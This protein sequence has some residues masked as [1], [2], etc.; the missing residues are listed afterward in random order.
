MGDLD[1][2]RTLAASRLLAAEIDGAQLIV[3]EGT[4]QLPS[5]ERPTKFNRHVLSF[6]GRS[7]QQPNY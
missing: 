2:P 3:I 5:M 1:T 6:L 7:P 4:A